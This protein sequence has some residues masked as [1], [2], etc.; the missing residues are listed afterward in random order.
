MSS[1]NDAQEP[2][3]EGAEF[4]RA[5][6]QEFARGVRNNVIAEFAIQGL[7]VAGIVVLA[8]ML[9]PEDFGLFRV[10][11]VVSIFAT[12]VSDVGFP[13]ALVQRKEITPEHESTVWWASLALAG[14][15]ASLLYV[16]APAIA[17]IMAMP[18]L[19]AGMRLIC[20]PILLEG[21]AVTANARLRRR[22]N[23]GAL[24]VADVL[25]EIAFLAVAFLLLFFNHPRSSLAGGLAARFAAHA[26]AIWIADGQVVIG[27]PR[28]AAIRDLGRFSLSVLGANT[29]I[30][31]SANADYLLVGRLLG[32]TALGFYSISW[33]LLRFI[34]ARLHRVAV[35][36]IVP[37]FSRLQ[38]DDHELSRAYRELV[39]YL[40]RVV[41]PIIACIS[42]AAPE[43]LAAL[44]G[45]QWAPAAMPMRLLAAGLALSGL[46]EGIGSIFYAKDHPSIDLHLNAIRFV[47]IVIAVTS[48][49]HAGLFGV[50][51]GMSVVEGVI[52][53]VGIYLACQLIG[54]K[55]RALL[56]AVVPGLRVTSW[57]VIATLAG[58]A[59]AM[60]GEFDGLVVLALVAIPPALVFVALQG[61]E[62][63][64]LLEKAFGKDPVRALE[65]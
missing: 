23:F 12:L 4:K 8:R 5:L 30:C 1:R 11:I 35:R 55:L 7:R 25:G 45:H 27:R 36:V 32:T 17:R 41:L 16:T 58:K 44:Y 40:A 29:A 42:L 9:R 33:D 37:A 28:V 39:G 59:I 54:L 20:L 52:A 21:S 38:D 2:P 56:P 51:A 46:R 50:S 13:D 63:N 19:V 49:A 57:C 10:L 22:L 14:A 15:S 31:V 53:V 65:A 62:I 64:L 61:S 48:L 34:T 3:R 26:L 24:A 18:E 47:L 43:V 6:W 60:F